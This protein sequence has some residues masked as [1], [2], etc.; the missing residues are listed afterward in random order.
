MDIYLRG[1]ARQCWWLVPIA[2]IERLSECLH[3][4]HGATKTASCGGVP[5]SALHRRYQ[6]SGSSSEAPA[7]RLP[8]QPIGKQ[9]ED[10]GQLVAS[11]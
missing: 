4:A 5:C 11:K 1:P 8:D 6:Q 10:K 2:D 7:T 9:M 3:P